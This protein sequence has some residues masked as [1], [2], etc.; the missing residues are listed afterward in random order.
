M[1]EETRVIVWGGRPDWNF[2]HAYIRHERRIPPVAL[3]WRYD[4][5]G[6][7]G[8]GRPTWW[9]SAM[10]RCPECEWLIDETRQ[11]Y[12]KLLGES[13]ANEECDSISEVEL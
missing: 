13:D 9:A 5:V 3:Q 11:G 2:A 1:S 4:I 8:A 6:A 12:K 7:C 10:P